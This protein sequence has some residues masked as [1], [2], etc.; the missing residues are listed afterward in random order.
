MR[1]PWGPLA[2]RRMPLSRKACAPRL[3]VA[4][5]VQVL[6]R[7]CKRPRAGVKTK[8]PQFQS[9]REE[10]DD[11][12]APTCSMCGLATDSGD[13]K[14]DE[15][16]GDARTVQ[17]PIGDE[18]AADAHTRVHAEQDQRAASITSRM[19]RDQILQRPPIH[20]SDELQQ[21]CPRKGRVQD[22]GDHQ[23]SPAKRPR[24]CREFGQPK[25]GHTCR[26]QDGDRPPP[27][28]WTP[29]TCTPP[30]AH[31]HSV[32]DMGEPKLGVTSHIRDSH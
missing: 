4:V 18:G 17:G 6:R 28:P 30:S 16:V 12:L 31:S 15:R 25:H 8:A 32:H 2:E 26:F 1:R 23:A 22:D 11:L 14:C 7:L 21:Y 19:F 29:P 24:L 27:P 20:T 9:A 13:C 10:W 5:L 3:S